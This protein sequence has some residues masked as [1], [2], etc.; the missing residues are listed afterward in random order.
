M[1]NSKASELDNERRLLAED[2][3]ILGYDS[4]FVR[5]IAEDAYALGT[6]GRGVRNIIE[7][8]FSG[9]VTKIVFDDDTYDDKN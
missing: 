1:E 9:I 8:N 5:K 2:N 6:G 7:Q 4:K 3:I